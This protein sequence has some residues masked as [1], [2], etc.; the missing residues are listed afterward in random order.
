MQASGRGLHTPRPSQ[1][2]TGLSQNMPEPVATSSGR[3]QSWLAQQ[4][5]GGGPQVSISTQTQ[6]PSLTTA[7]SR[8]PHGGRTMSQ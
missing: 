8:S 6:Q 1:S 5:F 4:I 7:T 2:P 3:T